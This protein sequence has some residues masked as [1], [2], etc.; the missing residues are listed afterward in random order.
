MQKFNPEKEL[1]K[2]QNTNYRRTTT[3][4]SLF[5]PVL[6]LVCSLMAIAGTSFS[7]NIVGTAPSHTISIEMINGPVDS[8]IRKVNNGPFEDKIDTDATF[9]SITCQEGNLNYDATTNTIYSENIKENTKC[10]LSYVNDGTKNINLASLNS[11]NDNIGTSYYYKG[12]ST[13]NYISINNTIFR[14]VRVNGDGSLR[15]ILND[16]IS[17]SILSD[18][19]FPNLSNWA[20]QFNSSD[21]EV[22]KGDFDVANYTNYDINLYNLITSMGEYY[23]YGGLLSV[24][25]AMLINEGVS[26]SYLSNM[27]LSN[28]SDL[29]NVWLIN[30]NGITTVDKNTASNIRPVINV[31]VNQLK[32]QGTIEMPYHVN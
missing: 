28:F 31:K 9:G 22:T 21:I 13:N 7:A 25:E 6:V 15:L 3:I 24:R 12:D 32:G 23:D 30:E 1:N 4:K 27:L 29:N 26:N 20:L 17:T 14:I 19:L 16:S 11:I 5:I 8:Y 18:D 10:I 2:I